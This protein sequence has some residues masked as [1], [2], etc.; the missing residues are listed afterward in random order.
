MTLNDVLLHIDS[1]PEATP[2][3]AIDQAVQFVARVGGKLSALAVQVKIPLH[4]NRVADY[5]IGLTAIARDEEAKSLAACRESLDHFTAK[6]RE[7]EVFGEALLDA[8]DLYSVSDHVA[9]RARTRDLCIVPL[10]KPLYGQAEVVRSVIFA[11]GRPALVFYAQ[12]GQIAHA[13]GTVVVA[14]DGS[15]RAA[16][17]L[18]DALPILTAAKAV[19][20]FTAVNEKPSAVKGMGADVV[21]HLQAH[22]VAATADDVETDGRPIGTVLDQYLKDVAAGLVVMGAYGRP[23]GLRDFVW[24][25]ATEHMLHDPN[26]PLFLSH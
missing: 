4:S 11:S 2:P 13:P 22:G 25:G 18:A 16:R 10:A 3:E 1:Y 23:S 6:A 15:Q 7:A 12:N 5:L 17:A 14:W 19:R 21:R 20:V 9:Q 24:G 8:V 26:I